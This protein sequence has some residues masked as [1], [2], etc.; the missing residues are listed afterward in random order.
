MIVGLGSNTVRRAVVRPIPRDAAKQDL[1]HGPTSLMPAHESARRE[2]KARRP[3]R[4]AK[5]YAV[6]REQ[7]VAAPV[8]SLLDPGRPS[9]V[10]GLVVPVVVDPI[11]GVIIAGPPAHI[12]NEQREGRVPSLANSNPPATISIPVLPAHRPIGVASCPHAAPHSVLWNA[13]DT[14]STGAT[15]TLGP[16]SGY[17][18]GHDDQSGTAYTKTLPGCTVALSTD[19]ADHSQ[20]PEDLSFQSNHFRHDRIISWNAIGGHHGC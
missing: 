19:L 10:S 3:R 15:A 7:H 6:V 4:D 11:D 1:V 17:V 18:A 12:G 8:A 13:A 5:R 14:F 2:A 16:T 20:M 9:A